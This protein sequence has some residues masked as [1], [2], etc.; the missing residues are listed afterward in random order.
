MVETLGEGGR[1]D[2]DILGWADSSVG[3]YGCGIIHGWP[4]GLCILWCKK[5]GKEGYGHIGA[6][7]GVDKA[8]Y[9]PNGGGSCALL[10]GHEGEETAEDSDFQAIKF[11]PSEMTGSMP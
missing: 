8:S 3:T 6:N 11:P 9:I 4:Y 1:V 5:Y 2:G 7:F 10:I